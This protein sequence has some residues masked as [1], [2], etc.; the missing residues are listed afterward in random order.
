MVTG[1]DTTSYGYDYEDRLTSVTPPGSS[2]ITYV[3]NGL[4]SR[5]G[6]GS[7]TYRRA[8]A[9]AGSPLLGDGSA[10]YTP[11]L[12][13]R[14]GGQ[15]S[16]FHWGSFGDLSAQSNGSGGLTD[17]YSYDWFLGVLGHTGSSPSPIGA[18]GGYV[19]P[20]TGGINHGG[21]G[22]YEPGLG[23]GPS[24]AGMLVP[25]NGNV[26]YGSPIGFTYEQFSHYGHLA[27]DLL[28]IIDPTGIADG[29]NAVWYAA[30]G[31]YANAAISAGA[32]IPIAGI[33]IVG[34]RLAKKGASVVDNLPAGAASYESPPGSYMGLKKQLA[35][36]EALATPNYTIIAGPGAARE[37]R[38]ASWTAEEFGG[39]PFEW[40]KVQGGAGKHYLAGSD[41]GIVVH[42]EVNLYTGLRVKAKTKIE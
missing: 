27:L 20:D 19:D 16:F 18:G 12:S 24:V 14:R 8:G 23:G 21:G 6:R 11:G 41:V 4:G 39:L 25:D 7:E 15:S 42:F 36:E 22:E 31:D 40:V 9:S 5:V 13:E 26:D 17:L 10:S 28:G 37:F 1:S 33:A 30:E 29:V 2:A 35:I 38:N 32:I 3:Y 34:A